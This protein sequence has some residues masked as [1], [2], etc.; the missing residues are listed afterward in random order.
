MSAPIGNKFWKS[1][2]KH[3]RDRLFATPDDLLQS[4][5]EYFQWADE[6]P[7]V[8]T[9]KVVSDNNGK[10]IEE[11]PTQRPYTKKAWYHFIHCSDTWLKEFKKNCSEDFL[12]VINEIE[13]YIEN[14]QWEGATVGVFNHNIIARTLGLREN[15]D[16]TT[17]GDK[18]ESKTIQVEIVMPDTEE[19]DD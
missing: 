18:I 13:D 2:H 16:I 19:D 1:R 11:K 17:K 7:W 10:T 5:V 8:T 4:A 3:G 6:N 14:Q 9:K 15:S 12:L